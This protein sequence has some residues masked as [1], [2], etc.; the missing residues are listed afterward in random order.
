MPQVRVH[1]QILS[2]G[3]DRWGLVALKYTDI[4]Y[5]VFSEAA[6][7]V[8][9]GASPYE[10]STY[11]YTPLLA[12]MMIPNSL[13]HES[14][15]KWMFVVTD[16]LIGLCLKRIIT[17]LLRDQQSRAWIA[18][19]LQDDAVLSNLLVSLWLFNPIAI[20]VSTRGNAEAL[21]SLM[22]VLSIDL[23][24]SHCYILSAIV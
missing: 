18:P 14:I 7:F 12:W 2:A 13:I 4:D 5:R 15:G 20:N 24:L 22:V 23:L 19:I 6:E 3:A 11:R 21:I 17:K 8:V 1:G 16:I 9:A 10:R